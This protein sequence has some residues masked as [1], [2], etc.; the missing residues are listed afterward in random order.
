MSKFFQS[1]EI[2]HLLLCSLA[3]IGGIIAYLLLWLFPHQSI[4]LK[5]FTLF[6]LCV[7]LVYFSYHFFQQL[8]YKIN[9][10]SNLLEAVEQGRFQPARGDHW[11]G[12]L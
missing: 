11:G 6:V 7:T 5:F 12:G 4:Y 9:V 10:I 3:P 2:R 8:I 1:F